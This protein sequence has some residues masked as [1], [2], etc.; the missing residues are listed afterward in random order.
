MGLPDLRPG[1]RQ[2]VLEGNLLLRFS[3]RILSLALTL[4]IPWTLENPAQSRMWLTPGMQQLRRKR[5]VS[6][7]TFEMCMFGMGSSIVGVWVSLSSF[8]PFRCIGAKRGCCKRTGQPHDSLFGL[9]PNGEWK[10]HLAQS[11]PPRMCKILG[12]CFLS[13]E[14][15][16][17][18]EQFA[19]RLQ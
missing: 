15:E 11:Y 18:A 5:H 12:R 17:R 6:F 2:K 13:F 8:E 16:Q 19:K 10:T 9:L 4:G 1:D 14:A 3:L 7:A